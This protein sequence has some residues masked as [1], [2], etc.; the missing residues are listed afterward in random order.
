MK[1][2][3]NLLI[4]QADPA[5]LDEVLADERSG[6]LLAVR[7]APDTAAVRRQDYKALLKRLDRLGQIPEEVGKW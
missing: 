5:L 4:F 3:R 2:H 1:T 6:R 7:L